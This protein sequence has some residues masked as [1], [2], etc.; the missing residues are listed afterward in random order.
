MTEVLVTVFLEY[1]IHL[2]PTWSAPGCLS[3]NNQ[4]QFPELSHT[5]IV[6]TYNPSF[7]FSVTIYLFIHLFI[8]FNSTQA[9]YSQQNLQ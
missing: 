9:N 8:Y 7:Y 4:N 6:S 2:P 3:L 1:S 5:L